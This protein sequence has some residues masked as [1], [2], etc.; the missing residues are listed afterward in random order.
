MAD[1]PKCANDA[2]KC[3]VP[4]NSEFGKYCSDHCKEVGD[5]IELR[6]DCGHPACKE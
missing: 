6:C 5:L 2:C 4:K 3:L 1:Q